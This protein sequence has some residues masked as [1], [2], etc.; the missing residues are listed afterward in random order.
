VDVCGLASSY[1][2]RML[3]VAIPALVGTAAIGTAGLMDALNKADASWALGGGGG[4]GRLFDVRL[5]GLSGRAVMCRDGVRLHPGALARTLATPDLVVVPGLDDDLAPSFELNRR[6]V[7]WITRWHQAGARIASSCTGAFLVAEA[8]VL[9]GRAATTH[10]LFADE[11][12][13]RAEYRRRRRSDDDRPRRP[14]YFRRGD[15]VS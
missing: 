10:W 8:G 6:W 4:A 5:V 9:R 7:P 14:D 2:Q 12:K 15:S 13:R 1:S 11:L 3:L